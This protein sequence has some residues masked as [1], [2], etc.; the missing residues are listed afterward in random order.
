MRLPAALFSAE[1]ARLSGGSSLTPE[2]VLVTGASSGIGKS[3]AEFLA[4]NGYRVYGVSRSS[5]APS[6]DVRDD[7]SVRAAVADL[8]AREGRIDIVVNNAGIALAGA[9]EDTSI[10]EAIAQFD[11]NFFGVL[12][13]CRAVLPHMREQRSGCIVNIGSIAGLVA[14]PFQGL[15]SAS[16]FALEGLSEALRLEVRPF[17]IRVVL[18]DPGDHRT[19]L[20]EN[21]RPTAASQENP[22]YRNRYDRAVARMAAD[23]RNGPAPEAVARLLHRIIQL[24]K[25]RLRYTVGPIAERA[26]P[27]LKRALPHAVIE[28]LMDR[29]YSA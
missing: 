15:Y 4:R 6:M 28:T 3:C 17:G 11:V 14:V 2:V 19:N 23:E 1:R 8:I 24:K 5:S 22:A 27:L 29:Y 9:V 26:V 7:A 10:Q 25:P 18:I 20:T 21:R 12:R 13:V 16:K